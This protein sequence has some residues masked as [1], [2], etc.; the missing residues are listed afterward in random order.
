MN[1]RIED[2][3]RRTLRT[4]L[5][6]EVRRVINE[7]GSEVDEDEGEACEGD[8]VGCDPF[9]PEE[10]ELVPVGVEDVSREDRS[11]CGALSVELSE[12]RTRHDLLVNAFVSVV[13]EVL[14]R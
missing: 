8:G 6:R 7:H 10:D 12:V 5:R 1:S 3:R 14:E 11:V 9:R 2:P 4:L 13:V